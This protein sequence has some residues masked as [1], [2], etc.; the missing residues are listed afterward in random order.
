MAQDIV[1]ACVRYREGFSV[2]PITG[3]NKI[4][5]YTNTTSI[6]T[7]KVL[8]LDLSALGPPPYPGVVPLRSYRSD[9]T[10]TFSRVLAGVHR[11]GYRL[12]YTRLD[13]TKSRISLI[14]YVNMGVGA[15]WALANL[16]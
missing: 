10:S 16:I 6:G 5:L 9:K 15:L 14:I 2:G 1:V 7:A 4:Y 13:L 3:Q 12:C 11:S 8:L